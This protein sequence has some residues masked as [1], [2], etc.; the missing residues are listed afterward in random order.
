MQQ[1]DEH[2]RFSEIHLRQ[3]REARYKYIPCDYFHKVQ[4]Q[5]KLNNIDRS[6]RSSSFRVGRHMGEPFGFDENVFYL[7]QR[8]G[9][10]HGYIVKDHWAVYLS[11]LK[12]F[13]V[14]MLVLKKIIKGGQIKRQIWKNDEVK[15]LKIIKVVVTITGTV[16]STSYTQ[17]PIILIAALWSRQYIW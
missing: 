13:K 15:V 8:Y 2:H 7:D 1:H 6:H 4:K 12:H 5:A 16:W 14:C 9:Y 3:V 11:V 17:S 10:R